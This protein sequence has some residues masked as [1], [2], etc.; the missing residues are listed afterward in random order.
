MYIY[1]VHI[2][3]AVCIQD[4]KILTPTE[5][6]RAAKSTGQPCSG[7]A[8]PLPSRAALSVGRLPTTDPNPSSSTAWP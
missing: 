6:C 5:G 7:R 2:A 1:L 8:V 4:S 3:Q